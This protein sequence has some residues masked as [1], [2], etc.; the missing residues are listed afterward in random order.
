[1]RKD[2]TI[3]LVTWS[4]VPAALGLLTRLPIRV[5]TE[6]AIARG[7]ASAWAYP[8]V[9]ICIALI[10]GGFATFFLWLSLPHTI[11]AAF[12]LVI[13]VFLTGAMHEDGLADCAD[14]LWGGW[15]MEGRLEIM[16]DSHIGTYGVIALILSMM[17]RFLALSVVIEANKFW[18][19]LILTATISRTNMVVLM[20]FL[21]NAREGGLSRSVGRPSQRTMLVSCSVSVLATLLLAFWATPLILMT[22]ALSALACATIAKAKVGGQTGDVLGATQ[23]VTEIML[24]ILFATVVF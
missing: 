16:K 19:A 18:L 7:A 17:L 8:V 4:D 10:T 21:P 9:G 2:N 14:G 20:T 6:E 24:F 11:I 15:T 5:E 13:T 22:A 12:C 23:Q 1:M 3:P